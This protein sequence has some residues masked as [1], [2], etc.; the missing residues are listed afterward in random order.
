[1]DENCMVLSGD[2]VCGEGGTWDF[3]I[4]KNRMGRM[5]P[6]YDGIGCKEL[7]GNVL[8]EFKLD[9]GRFRV[10]LSYWPPTSFELATGIRIPP[11]LITNEGAV[12]YFCQHQKVKGGMNLFAKF[13]RKT[14]NVDNEVVDDSGMGFCLTKSCETRVIDIADDSGMGFVSPDAARFGGRSDLGC[15][16]SKKRYVSSAYTKTRVIDIANDDELVQEVEKLEEKIMSEGVKG[17]SSKAEDESG[18]SLETNEEE[19]FEMDE[20]SLRPKGYDK[21]F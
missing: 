13:E 3:V 1:M 19:N 4:E 7:E 20:I 8:R 9:E 14:N 10:S 5:V 12:K 16:S 2:W 18:F 6:I 17:E 21:E 15:G 11:V